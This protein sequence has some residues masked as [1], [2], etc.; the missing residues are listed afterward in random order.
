M[1]L[2]ITGGFGYIGGRLAR[3][4]CQDG[5][6]VRLAS[7]RSRVS[8]K[9]GGRIEF[10]TVDWD[11]EISLRKVCEGQDVIIHTSGLGSKE[12][13]SDPAA[14]FRVNAMFTYRL[15]K[16]ASESRVS[17]LVYL[18]TAHVYGNPLC[19]RI[20]EDVA[21]ANDHP[22]AKSNLEG[23]NSLLSGASSSDMSVIIVRLSNVVGAP[24]NLAP[25]C[26]TLLAGDLCKQAVLKRELVLRSN[27]LIERDFIPMSECIRVIKYFVESV[28]TNFQLKVFNVG[29]GRSRSL[30]EMAADISDIT[31]EKLGYHP[32]IVELVNRSPVSKLDYVCQR[33]KNLGID[34]KPSISQELSGMIDF[35][36][37]NFK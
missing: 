20:D 2:L 29:S 17:R 3:S 6:V 15:A 36:E 14:A 37:E 11:D 13:E 35:V 8:P 34:I 30:I 33:I 28:E 22:Y 4:L 5:H 21:P 31:K 1:N 7:R 25:N 18:S 12:C 26:W 32:D 10:A 19:G 24:A 9:D 23:E 16:T 27:A